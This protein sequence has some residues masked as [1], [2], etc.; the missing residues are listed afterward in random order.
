[1][2]KLT[3]AIL[4]TMVALS[5]ACNKA[6]EQRASVNQASKKAGDVTKT[7]EPGKEQTGSKPEVAE[8]K[9][10]FLHPESVAKFFVPNSD[11]AEAFELNVEKKT[12][13]KRASSAFSDIP[14][15]VTVLT[16]AQ[17]E[18]IQKMM[19]A[20]GTKSAEDVEAG[21]CQNG[22][23]AGFFIKTGETIV[24][25]AEKCQSNANQPFFLN[26]GDIASLMGSLTKMSKASSLDK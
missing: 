6:S 4:Y 2:K 23:A 11:G 16:S 13:T 1:M 22:Q 8:V 25:V 21:V 20:I 3:I 24:S 26:Y 12:L 18:E 10:P 14:E 19:T 9:V 5:S 17:I 7:I 15:T